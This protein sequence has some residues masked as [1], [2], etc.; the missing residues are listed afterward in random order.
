[1]LRHQM[2]CDL[3]HDPYAKVWEC[4]RKHTKV[5]KHPCHDQTTAIFLSNNPEL[6]PSPS[7]FSPELGTFILQT[8]LPFAFAYSKILLQ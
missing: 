5:T 3:E 6:C 1:M 8:I 7:A 2:F 4:A